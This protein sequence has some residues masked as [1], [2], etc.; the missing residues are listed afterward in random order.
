MALSNGGVAEKPVR[1]TKT[2]RYTFDL[3]AW[4]KGESIA[5]ATLTGDAKTTL[6]PTDINGGVI[7]WFATGVEKGVSVVHI[8][9]T[10]ATRSDCQT[11]RIVVVNNC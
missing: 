1:V 2:E 6:S 4:L 11:L 5:S 3:T 9:Y 10:T 7:G 8:D